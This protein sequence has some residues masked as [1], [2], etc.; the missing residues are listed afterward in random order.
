MVTSREDF[1]WSLAVVRERRLEGRVHVLF[2]PVW[3][4][5]EPRALA[6]WMLESGI[7]ARLSLQLHKVIWGAEARGV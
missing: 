7:D 3:G 6:A 4:K 5:V 2:S 1:D